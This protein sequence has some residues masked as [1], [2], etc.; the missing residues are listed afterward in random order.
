VQPEKVD[1]V[2]FEASD[3]FGGTTLKCPQCG[4]SNLHPVSVSVHRGNDKT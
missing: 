4:G 3:T 2:Q 1:F